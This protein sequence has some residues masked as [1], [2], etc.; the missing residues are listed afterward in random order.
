MLFKRFA[1]FAKVVD[2]HLN[3]VTDFNF[4]R[5]QGVFVSLNILLLWAS[6]AVVQPS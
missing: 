5:V 1:P 6:K 4:L 2:C 3:F